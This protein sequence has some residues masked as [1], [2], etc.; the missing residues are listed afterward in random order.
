MLGFFIFSHAFFSFNT[1]SYRFFALKKIAMELENSLFTGKKPSIQETSFYWLLFE[2]IFLLSNSRTKKVLVLTFLAS[3]YIEESDD[4]DAV[5]GDIF[6]YFSS[7]TLCSCVIFRR[8]STSVLLAPHHRWADN[9]SFPLSFS[10]LI[11]QHAPYTLDYIAWKPANVA[12]CGQ[13]YFKT[14][15]QKM[16]F[17]P[18][19]LM[20]QHIIKRRHHELMDA[21]WCVTLQR[22]FQ[23]FVCKNLT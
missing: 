5:K 3:H 23:F 22:D 13:D 14:G 12:G 6:S 9:V 1:H 15:G 7:V 11:G 19:I 20:S 2:V 8:K 21:K 10:L 17:F 4:T 18:H 16:C